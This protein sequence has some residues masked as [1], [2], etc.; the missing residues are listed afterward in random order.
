MA[1]LT[2]SH[3]G[4]EMAPLGAIRVLSLS[5]KHTSGPC[6]VSL[7]SIRG[8]HQVDPGPDQSLARESAGS[9]GHKSGFRPPAISAHTTFVGELILAPVCSICP[10]LPTSVQVYQ[11]LSKSTKI[12]QNLTLQPYLA[13]L[14]T[15]Y[16]YQPGYCLFS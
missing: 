9:N 4:P 16:R 10:N 3:Q 2:R 8:R 1:G 6:L 13:P 12:C 7:A 11:N 5:H 15:R 14:Y